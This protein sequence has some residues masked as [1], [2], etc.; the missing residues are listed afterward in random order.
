MVPLEL[1]MGETHVD[2]FQFLLSAFAFST[3]KVVTRTIPEIL[4]SSS[5]EMRMVELMIVIFSSLLFSVSRARMNKH[6]LI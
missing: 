1:A 5:S 6:S 2:I 3:T 4:W